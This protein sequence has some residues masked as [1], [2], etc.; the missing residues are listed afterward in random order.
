MRAMALT[1]MMALLIQPVLAAEVVPDKVIE[2]PRTGKWV[3]NLDDDSCSIGAAFGEGDGQIILQMFRYAPGDSFEVRLIGKPLE[4]PEIY[5]PL[6][7]GFG[8]GFDEVRPLAGTLEGMPL[9]LMREHRLMPKSKVES[10]GPVYPFVPDPSP[11]AITPEQEVAASA[12]TFSAP[13]GK[14][15]RLAAGS[16]KNPMAVL[17]DCTTDLVASWGYDPAQQAARKQS[18]RPISTPA[19]WLTPDDFPR[20]RSGRQSMN[21]VIVFRLDVS[22][23]GKVAKCHVLAAIG[24]EKFR[25]DTC[26]LITQRAKFKPALDANGKP[27]ASYYVNQVYWMWG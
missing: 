25:K 18:P 17:R 10:K 20:E 19:D 27:V 5:P 7:I 8:N 23:A 13:S 2:L 16:F 12:V 1:A 3:L 24:D 22:D 26:L 14:W 11:P 21:A 6:K 9:L 4:Q 15:Y